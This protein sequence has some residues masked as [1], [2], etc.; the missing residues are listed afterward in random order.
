VAEQF[1]TVDDYLRPLPENV[2]IIIDQ[3]RRTIRDVLPQSAEKISYNMPTITLNGRNLVHFA[4]W[5]HHIGL[6]PVPAADDAFERELAPYR[7]TKDTMRFPLRKPIPYDLIGRLVVLL[8][9]QRDT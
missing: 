3:I 6:Y 2:Q 5:K 7:G 8:V 9:E 1:A 4:A